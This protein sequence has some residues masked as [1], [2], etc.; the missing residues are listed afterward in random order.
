MILFLVGGKY[1]SPRAQYIRRDKRGMRRVRARHMVN[2]P[3]AWR[4]G[5]TETNFVTHITLTRARKSNNYFG[6]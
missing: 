6:V 1:I 4:I 2:I 5:Q 3:C